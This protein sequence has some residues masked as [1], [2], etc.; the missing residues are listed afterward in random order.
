MIQFNKPI[1]LNGEELITE[2]E[3]AGV[4]VIADDRNVKAPVIDGDGN[5]WLNISPS[6]EV[7]A[8]SVVAAHTG[9]VV[10][11]EPTITD[12]LASV[13][14]SIEELREALGSN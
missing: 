9:T 12:K 4:S 11:P 5:F 7:T 3:L 6:D 10:T 8:M 2:L 13:G 14:L 1:N